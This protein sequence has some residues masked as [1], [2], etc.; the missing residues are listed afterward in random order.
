MDGRKEQTRKMKRRGRNEKG[1]VEKRKGRE[2]MD[3]GR[4]S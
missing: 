2:R 1:K 4:G 3:I